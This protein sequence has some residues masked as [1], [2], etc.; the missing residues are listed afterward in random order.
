MESTSSKIL[1]FE[2]F[3][4]KQTGETG[5]ELTP[6]N[7]EFDQDATPAPAEMPAMGDAGDDHNLSVNM[8]GS[9][10]TGDDA[11]QQANAEVEIEASADD[12]D[13]HTEE[14]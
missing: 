1:S 7:T 5:P 6:A 13:S 3:V 10:E 9:E 14:N 8:M 12:V 2:E 11:A 4:T